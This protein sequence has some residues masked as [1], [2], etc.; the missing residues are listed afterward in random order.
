MPLDQV[1]ERVSLPRPIH[2]KTSMPISLQLLL[3]VRLVVGMLDSQTPYVEIVADGRD[4]I[5]LHSIQCQHCLYNLRCIL[6]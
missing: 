6:L 1:P 3:L 2:A 5:V 4:D